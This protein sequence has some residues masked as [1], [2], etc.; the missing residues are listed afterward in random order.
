VYGD[1]REGSSGRGRQTTVGLSTTAIFG[2]LSGYF[3]GKIRDKARPAILHGDMLP[4]VGL[5]L[6]AK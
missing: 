5:Q 6:I 3:F 2:E 4:L 1:I